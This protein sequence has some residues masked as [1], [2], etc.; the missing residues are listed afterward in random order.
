L[1][2]LGGDVEGR[3]HILGGGVHGR[4]MLQQQHDNVDIAQ[5]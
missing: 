1:A 3:V 2:L 5:P 4:A